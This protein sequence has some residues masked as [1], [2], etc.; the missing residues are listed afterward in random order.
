MKKSHSLTK[1]PITASEMAQRS[2][3]IRKGKVKR[4]KKTGRFS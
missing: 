1:T 3:K 2:W 4:D